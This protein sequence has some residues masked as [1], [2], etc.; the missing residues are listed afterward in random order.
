MSASPEPVGPREA[1]R[2]LFSIFIPT[3]NR[4]HTL[5]DALASAERQTFR[6]FEVVI[7]DDGSTDGT[8]AL[9][10][11]WQ[12]R[13]PFPI[14]YLRQPNQGKHAAH[15]NA[16]AHARGRLFMTLDSDDTLLPE[17]LERLAARWA[18]IPEAEREGFAG[19]G[20][21]CLNEDGSVS[22]EPYPEAVVDANYLEI[23]RRCKMNGERREAL[24]TDVLRQYPYPIIA[25]ERHVRP[26]LILRR[27]AHRYRIRFTNDLLQ[28]NRHAPDGICANR[29]R[30]RMRNPLGLRLY[31][32]E[33]IT[34]HDGYA[35]PRDL[36]ASYRQYI[37]FS[38]HG[39]IGLAAQ[40]AAVKDR[41]LW[42]RALPLGLRDWLV[43]VL[44][45]RLRGYK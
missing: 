20:W 36:L 15:N 26:T 10:S 33:E 41:A 31:Y 22:G 16:V 9:V 6:D 39:G 3:Y 34:L 8:P 18:S 44:K 2:F 27:M 13:A 7:V 1:P 43:D 45:I 29:F 5:G 38:L 23:H 4:A 30:Y 35:S 42:W 19:V 11:E 12:A 37:R 32:L 28:I 40:R 17:A 21:M 24:R 14:Q 25:G